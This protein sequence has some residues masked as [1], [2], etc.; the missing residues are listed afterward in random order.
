[1]AASSSAVPRPSGG[2]DALGEEFQLAQEAGGAILEAARP[3]L[4]PRPSRSGSKSS[5]P[6]HSVCARTA[7]PSYPDPVLS[8]G[9][10]LQ[11]GGPGLSD[12]GIDFRSEAFQE[13]ARPVPP[14]SGRCQTSRGRAAGRYRSPWE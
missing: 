6:W 3:E 9:Y 12:S 11:R 14:S 5:W 7:I 1:M 10:A 2:L 4:A 8:D 13:R